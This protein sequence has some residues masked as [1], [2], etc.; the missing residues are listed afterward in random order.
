MVMI[1][2]M[3]LGSNT[4]TFSPSVC[5]NV[6]TVFESKPKPKLAYNDLSKFQYPTFPYKLCHKS[7]LAKPFERTRPTC[8]TDGTNGYVC[9]FK[10]PEIAVVIPFSQYDLGVL[11]NLLHLLNLEDYFPC[12]EHKQKH[13]DLVFQFTLSL[14]DFPGLPELV[15]SS[16]GKARECFRDVLFLSMNLDELQ[17]QYPNSNCFSP[18]P[19]TMFS[20]LFRNRELLSRYSFIFMME[21]DVRPTRPLWVDRL[22]H[23]VTLERIDFWIKGSIAYNNLDGNLHL[24]G[25]AIYR[26]GDLDFDCFL[27]RA[28]YL[29]YPLNFDTGIFDTQMRSENL[30]SL[31]HFQSTTF[32]MNVANR[33]HKDFAQ[34]ASENY[35]VHARDAAK[36]IDNK[37][38]RYLS[39]FAC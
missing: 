39:R 1:L 11:L 37:N 4:S 19:N 22:V 14:L 18:S 5:P 2:V 21:V 15:I 38:S 34:S 26:M 23:E 6:L 33:Y 7:E 27:Q 24:N 20:A 30:E 13:V 31:H 28:L 12:T 10:V 25:N 8:T 16:L 3:T 17:D 36:F 35:M 9:D 29:H 32:L